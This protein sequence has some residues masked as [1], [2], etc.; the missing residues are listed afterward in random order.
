MA[1]FQARRV[2]D[3]VARVRELENI[4][5]FL[6][7]SALTLIIDLFFTFVFL[8]VMFCLFAAAGSIRNG[9]K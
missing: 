3:L 4:R 7:S 5:T 8:G 6:T 9:T 2:G 1:Y